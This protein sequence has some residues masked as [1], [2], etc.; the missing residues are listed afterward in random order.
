MF[1]Q[2]YSIYKQQYKKDQETIKSFDEFYRKPS[3]DKI[4]ELNDY[5]SVCIIFTE[6]LEESKN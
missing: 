4:T 3:E 6:C 2:K 1:L 5:E